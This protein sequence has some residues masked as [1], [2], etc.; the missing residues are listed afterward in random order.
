MH[1]DKLLPNRVQA[2]ARGIIQDSW[3]EYE[4]VR[5]C[6][7]SRS[8]FVST[9]ACVLQYAPKWINDTRESDFTTFLE[10][11]MPG[12]DYARHRSAI[13]GQYPASLGSWT[14][15]HN[16]IGDSSF[17]CNTRFLFDAYYRQGDASLYM[18]QYDYLADPMLGGAALHASD[19]PLFMNSDVFKA[20]FVNFTTTNLGIT[21]E[22]A[23]NLW[24]VGQRRYPQYQQYFAS[25]AG[26]GTPQ[27]DFGT[28]SA[29]PNDNDPLTNVMQV[30][31]QFDFSVDYP[32]VVPSFNT[33]QID[34]QN[35]KNICLFWRNMSTWVQNTAG[36]KQPVLVK[37]DDSVKFDL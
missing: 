26:T 37:Q 24:T 17:I 22:Q 10:Y 7:I 4:S 8:G 9:I 16:V 15:A 35:N 19:L 30:T 1:L 21:E 32:Y 27:G 29:P 3:V 31:T 12:D 25:F 18:M 20:D 14:R 6:R 23:G 33:S 2:T 28:W 36:A 5:R 34:T 13:S 11:F